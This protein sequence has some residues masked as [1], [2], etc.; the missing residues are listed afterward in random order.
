MQEAERKFA[1]NL[2][3]LYKNIR[4]VVTLHEDLAHGIERPAELTV[5]RFGGIDVRAFICPSFSCT[6]CPAEL[7]II[8]SNIIYSR[9]KLQALAQEYGQGMAKQ[10]MDVLLATLSKLFDLLE[11]SH[12]GE[13]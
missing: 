10:G 4:G 6:T 2:L 13:M 12:Q 1:S 8:V 11:T 9:L 5:G 3:A 7:V